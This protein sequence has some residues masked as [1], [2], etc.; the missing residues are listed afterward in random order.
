S[1]AHAQDRASPPF[2]EEIARQEL[3]Y[4]SRGA[5]VPDGYVIDRSLTSYTQALASEFD[6]ALGQLR[7]QDRWLDIG[8]GRGQAILDYYTPKFDMLHFEG[9]DERG[10]KA[11][12]VGMSIEDRRTPAWHEK[13][14]SLPPGKIQYL[15]SRRLREYSRDELGM[16][17][18]ITDVVG[19]FS[20]TT[21]LTLYMERVL[22][23]L[24]VGGDFFTVLA[25]V[26][27]QDGSNK[28]F[29]E[30]SPYLTAIARADGSEVKVCDWLKSIK[31]VQATCE[32]KPTW[33]PPIEAFHVHKVCNQVAVPA[34]APVHFEAGTPPERGF[35]LAN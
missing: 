8:A 25:D 2:A 16:F 11:Q 20:Y 23:S 15:A 35:K 10:D 1:S 22:E 28:P 29:Y 19:G 26:S 13:A 7:P 24:R 33:K 14:A 5:E 3:I 21:D 18:L 9:R 17:K 6:R 34:L 27:S 12:S 30:G 32:F 31:C 4:K